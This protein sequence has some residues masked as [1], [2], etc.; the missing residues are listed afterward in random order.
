MASYR[1]PW[2]S[3]REPQEFTTEVK[4]V[5]LGKYTRYQRI[6][7]AYDFVY[8]GMCFAQRA[9]PATEEEIDADKFAQGNLMRFFGVRFG[10]T[11]DTEGPTQCLEC[12]SV[13][14]EY[15]LACSLCLAK[16]KS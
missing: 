14:E 1:N 16:M 6:P 12:G 8:E 3:E 10:P 11:W 2:A 4:S 7:G 9:G 15:V 5:R 13:V